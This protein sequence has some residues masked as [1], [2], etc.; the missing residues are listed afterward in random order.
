MVSSGVLASPVLIETSPPTA[1]RRPA[2]VAEGGAAGV[3]AAD[4]HVGLLVSAHLAVAALQLAQFLQLAIVQRFAVLSARAVGRRFGGVFGIRGVAARTRRAGV[5]R[6]GAVAGRRGRGGC[7][8][9]R[10]LACRRGFAS[11]RVGIGLGAFLGDLGAR[12]GGLFARAGVAAVARVALGGVRAG[13]HL[14][15]ER[16]VRGLRDADAVATGAVLPIGLALGARFGGLATAQG[17]L[18]QERLIVVD[19]S[20]RAADH[21]DRH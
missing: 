3:A 7:S 6:A 16:G 5:F 19:L 12:E 2:L 14:A 10:G 15:F 4:R 13:G 18:C 11:G 21:H 9:R 17:G 8:I 1:K 20:D